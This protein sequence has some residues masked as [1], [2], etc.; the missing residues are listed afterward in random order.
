MKQSNTCRRYD[1]N[2]IKVSHIVAGQILGDCVI[3]IPQADTTLVPYI[4]LSRAIQ[5]IYLIRIRPWYSCY[6][7]SLLGEAV[8]YNTDAIT[9]NFYR[10]INAVTYFLSQIQY[11]KLILNI[12][13]SS[14]ENIHLWL[15]VYW[16][17]VKNLLNALRQTHI[18]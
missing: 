11:Y 14:I 10:N 18:N 2:Q 5:T 1:L 12:A 6:F 3:Q 8:W 9:W 4:C 17:L 7:I 15:R 16:Q 13:I